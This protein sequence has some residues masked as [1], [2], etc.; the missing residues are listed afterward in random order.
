M[1][2][3]GWV[4]SGGGGQEKSVHCCVVVL[5]WRCFLLFVCFASSNS[6]KVQVL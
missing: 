2:Q 4:L 3:G 1:Q 5:I 6:G